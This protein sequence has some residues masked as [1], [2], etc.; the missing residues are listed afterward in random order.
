M[1][2]F[3]EYKEICKIGEGAFGYVFKATNSQNQIVAI[4][5]IK[6]D[7]DEEGIPSTALR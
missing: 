7:N 3:S 2:E 4:K 5:H 6:F 1:K